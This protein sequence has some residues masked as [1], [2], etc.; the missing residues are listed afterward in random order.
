MPALTGTAGASPA[1]VEFHV[2]RV[3]GFN[4]DLSA[5]A[6]GGRGARG[7]RKSRPRPG[8][9]ST[10][11]SSALGFWDPECNR[12]IRAPTS[13]H[14]NPPKPC[15]STMAVAQIAFREIH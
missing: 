11:A 6:W 7:P 13:G 12:R 9:T 4:R 2:V 14:I 3:V 8:L 5:V 10:P 1:F 15:A